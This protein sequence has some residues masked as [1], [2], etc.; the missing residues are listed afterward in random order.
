M[1]EPS[2]DREGPGRP[3]GG[4][5]L[6]ARA[7]TRIYARRNR[8]WDTLIDP[9]AVRTYMFGAEVVTDWKQGSPIAWKGVWEGKSYEDRGIILLV[10]PGQVLRFSHYSP[11]SGLADTPEN[12]HTVTIELADDG[13]YT[14]VVLTQDNNRTA[15]ARDHSR[16]NWE[17]MLAGLKSLLEKE[18]RERLPLST[19]HE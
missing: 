1:R 19:D 12:Y 7:E 18:V 17:A 14:K 2:P 15:E 16:K 3:G 11:R 5:S 6:V 4:N 8:V 10:V 9:E 13:D